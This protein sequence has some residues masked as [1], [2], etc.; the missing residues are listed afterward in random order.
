MNINSMKESRYLKKE[1]VWEGVC[2]MIKRLIKANV[3]L[4]DHEPE[5]K[6]IVY[7][8]EFEKGMVLNWTNIQLIAVALGTEETDQWPGKQIV[9]FDDPNVSFGGKLT[10]GIRV[11]KVQKSNLPF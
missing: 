4:P 3:A 10:G 8:E 1:D 5:E 7:F 11:R 6:W 2:V 9:L